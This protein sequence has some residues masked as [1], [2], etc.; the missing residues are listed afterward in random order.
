MPKL[1]QIVGIDGLR[2]CSSCKQRLPATAFN[3]NRTRPDGLAYICRSC[4]ATYQRNASLLRRFGIDAKTFDRILAQQHG[5]CAICGTTKGL[6]VGSRELRLA[7]DHDHT[8]GAVRGILCHSCNNGI[9]R[10]GDDPALLRR[11]ADYLENK[12]S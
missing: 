5:G 2:P 8:T 7:V 9:G 11:A 12:E 6:Q 4:W 1:V 10:F 3:K